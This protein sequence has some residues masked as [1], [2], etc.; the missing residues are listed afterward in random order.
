MAKRYGGD[1]F[2]H[3]QRSR[4]LADGCSHGILEEMMANFVHDLRSA[5]ALLAG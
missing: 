5:L 1:F 3:G 4:R 2:G